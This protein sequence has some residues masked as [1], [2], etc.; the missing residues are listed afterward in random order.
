M[1]PATRDLFGEI[2]VTWPEVRAWLL[3]VPGIDPDSYRAEAYIKG[4]DVPGKVAAAKLRGDFEQLVAR[5]P[6]PPQWWSTRFT[7][8]P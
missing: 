2:P 1:R 4:Y 8:R 3:A 5:E 7:W 6:P